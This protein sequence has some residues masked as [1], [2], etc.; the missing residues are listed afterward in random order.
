VTDPDFTHA[1][2]VHVVLAD[3][4]VLYSRVLRDYLLYAATRRIITVNWSQSILNDVAD[5][6]SANIAGFTLQRAG[7][8][9]AKMTEAFPVAQV[10][11]S[12]GDYARLSSY[13]L[14][15]E[16]D[17][18]V[19]AAALAAGADI[20]CTNNIVHFPEPV[21]DD[22]DLAALTPDELFCRLF[23]VQEDA[24]LQV[25]RTTVQQFPKATD[26]STIAAL[27]KAQAQRTADRVAALVNL[28]TED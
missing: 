15:D 20:I 28:T 8:L 4:N 26:A 11:P 9:L 13:A 16:D 2:P 25:H 23:D 6:M 18:D 22:L 1:A 10:E 5:H 21:M 14:P 19:I 12:P 27:R 17:R 24:M 3:A 7:Y